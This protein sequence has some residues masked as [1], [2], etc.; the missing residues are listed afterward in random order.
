MAPVTAPGPSSKVR[1]THATLRGPCV[2]A[3]TLIYT[4]E[5]RTEVGALVPAAAL[6]AAETQGGPPASTGFVNPE[7]FFALYGIDLCP[8]GSC[9]RQYR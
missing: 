9:Q 7:E 4:D 2:T 3:G 5:L 8:A 1:A 6:P